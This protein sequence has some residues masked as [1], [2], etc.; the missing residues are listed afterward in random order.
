MILDT[1]TISGYRKGLLTDVLF[2]K[3]RDQVYGGC[4]RVAV[5]IL[6]STVTIRKVL[7]SSSS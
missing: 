4:D 3:P 5:S 6:K 2:Y 1:E 7:V